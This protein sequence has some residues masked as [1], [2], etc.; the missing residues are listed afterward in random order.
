MPGIIHPGLLG[1]F[2][3]GAVAAVVIKQ[4]AFSFHAPG[5]AL[6]KNLLVAAELFVAAEGRELIHVQLDVTRDKQINVT[7]AVVVGPG[8]AGHEAAAAHAGFFSHVL[9]FAISQ[10]TVERAAAEAGDE[11]V[12][13]A[14]IVEVGDRNSHAPALA[15]QTGRLRDVRELE[16]GVLMVEGDERIAAST[17][18]IDGRAIHHG[19]VQF[20]VMVAI[21]KS[22]SAAHG[23]DD[24]VLL[25]CRDMRRGQPRLSG[26]VLKLGKRRGDRRFCLGPRVK[27]GKSEEE[28]Q[29]PSHLYRPGMRIRFFVSYARPS[30]SPKFRVSPCSTHGFS[31]SRLSRFLRRLCSMS[32]RYVA[33]ASA[34]SFVR[35]ARR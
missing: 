33:R 18:A 21:E 7:V 11:N 23:F 9:E 24:V 35:P 28:S 10:A 13:L 31:D 22:N 14:V 1:D 34:A 19:N 2:L 16:V 15:R 3:E 17:I 32:L 25:E 27:T 26:D 6:D 4:V 29:K 30:R 20:A 8:R 12:Q 5:A